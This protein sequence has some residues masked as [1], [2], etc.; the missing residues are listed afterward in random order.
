MVHNSS[1]FCHTSS[2]QQVHPISSSGRR[3]CASRDPNQRSKGRHSCCC[4]TSCEGC[5]HSGKQQLWA[6]AHGNREE[7]S[8]DALHDAVL[9]CSEFKGMLLWSRRIA[10]SAL[11]TRGFIRDT[12]RQ[13]ES[14]QPR[15]FWKIEK[16]G[17]SSDAIFL[18]TIFFAHFWDPNLTPT[19]VA[20]RPAS[21]A[22]DPRKR[23]VLG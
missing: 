23:G 2:T 12:F 6:P 21:L 18:F 15:F 19:P 1:G 9:R 22:V 10:T 4:T 11:K 14:F 3:I 7:K 16:R 17:S 13:L 8:S 20:G 5:L